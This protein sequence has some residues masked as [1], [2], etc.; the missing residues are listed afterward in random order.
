MS[1][2]RSSF[3]KANQAIRAARKA[4]FQDRV[5]I[6]R[7]REHKRRNVL[8]HLPEAQRTFIGRK[9]NQAWRETD[10]ERA[11][12]EL[13]P[14]GLGDLSQRLRID[15]SALRNPVCAHCGRDLPPAGSKISTGTLAFKAPSPLPPTWEARCPGPKT[16][17]RRVPGPALQGPSRQVRLR[18]PTVVADNA[19]ERR[20]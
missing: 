18:G 9:L 6:A 2:A 1:R 17:P 4:T 8:D 7:C 13:S 3:G 16:Q 5:L 12:K 14:T 20:T 10:S 15:C 19:G 11:E